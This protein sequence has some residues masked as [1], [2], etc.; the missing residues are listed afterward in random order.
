M[1]NP[2]R[3]LTTS[4]H[5]KWWRDRK[6]NW[7]EHYTA[8][9]NHPH[10]AFLIEKLRTMAFGSLFEVGCAS[11][12]NLLLVSQNFPHAQIGGCDMNEDAITA[13]KEILPPLSVL[14]CD[15]AWAIFHSDNA[16]D[17]T[18][19]DA[20]L[21]YI[22]K[23]RIDQVLREMKRITRR[24]IILIEFHSTSWWQRL[25]LKL[26]SGYNAYDYR[27]LLEKHEFYDIEIT[28]LPDFWGAEPW[29][30]FGHM[31]TARP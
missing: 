9:I 2:F 16:T 1:P 24:Q 6:I 5:A 29:R 27:K 20:C 13:A 8:T 17:I 25:L 4:Q 14:Q 18:L 26:G 11:G 21:I 30:R 28:K 22:G 12:P 31:I 3:R 10:R 19:S 23:D 15:P 7:H